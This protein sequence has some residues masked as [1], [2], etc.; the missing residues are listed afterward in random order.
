MLTI[1]SVAARAGAILDALY[2]GVRGGE[3]VADALF[4]AFSPGGKMPYTTYAPSYAG[5]YNF[6]NMSIAAPQAYVDANGAARVTPGGRTYRY[7]AGG[8]AGGEDPLWPCFWGLSYTNFSLA[9]AAPPQA[10]LTLSPASPNA[11]LTVVLTNVGGRDG[12]EVVLLFAEPVAGTFAAA[13]PPFLPRRSLVGF[14]RRS[15]AA[16]A[17]AEVSFVV[18]APDALALTQADGSRAP[19]DGGVFR[20]VVGTGPAQPDVALAVEARLQG[21]P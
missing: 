15:L 4:G 5:M 6:T 12:D 20:L 3:A 13:P 16:G 21:W 17:R 11:T 10:P 18:A 19:V 8:D 1:P 9:W 7:Y 14:A 2:P